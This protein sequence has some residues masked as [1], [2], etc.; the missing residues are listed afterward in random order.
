MMRGNLCRSL[1][2]KERYY[3]AYNAMKSSIKRSRL[4]GVKMSQASHISLSTIYYDIATGFKSAGEMSYAIEAYQEALWHNPTYTRALN[5]IGNAFS[6]IGR[7]D[8]AKD[9]LEKVRERVSHEA[10][11]YQANFLQP[12]A[13]LFTGDRGLSQRRY[14]LLQLGQ[15]A[16]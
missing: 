1:I 3:D 13:S 16:D 14:W 12:V 4:A 11:A 9:Y 5:N 10:A 7:F 2:N 15:R 8:V 6:E